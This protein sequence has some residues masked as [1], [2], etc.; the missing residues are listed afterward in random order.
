MKPHNHLAMIAV[1]FLALCPA[2]GPTQPQGIAELRGLVVDSESGEP[3]IGATI[4][5]EGFAFG[6][7]TEIDGRYSLE[8]PSGIYTVSV[9]R[10]GYATKTVTGVNAVTGLPTEL[11][12]SLKP[13]AIALETEIVVTAKAIESAEAGL[14]KIQQRSDKVTDGI[15]AELIS[16][17]SSSDASDALKRVTGVTMVGKHT[18]VRGLGGR[19]G[20][21][22]LNGA[23]LPSPEPHRAIVPMDLF[24]ASLL[25]HVQITKNFTPDRPGDFAGGSVEIVA[26]EFPENLTLT[27]SASSGFNSVAVEDDMLF[28]RGGDTDWLGVDDGVRALPNVI[29]DRAA[30][31]RIAERGVGTDS[32]GFTA[33]E[34]ELFGRA[35][36]NQWSPQTRTSQL[37]QGYNFSLG[38]E[39]HI[40]EE[41]R[42]GYVFSLNY[43]N[44]NKRQEEVR[45]T[46]SVGA[47]EELSIKA[48]YD[49]TSGANEVLWGTVLNGSLRLSAFHNIA[50]KTMYNR[51]AEDEARIFT[52]WNDDWKKEVLNYRLRYIERGLLST[53]LSGNHYLYSLL[54]SDIRWKFTYSKVNRQEPDNREVLYQREAAEEGEEERPWRLFADN[55]QSG[56]R[57]FYDLTEDEISGSFDWE[58]PFLAPAGVASKLKFGAFGRTKERDFLVR[59]FRFERRQPN[60]YNSDFIDLTLVPE[61]LFSD[62]YIS[63]DPSIWRFQLLETTNYEDSYNA[64]HDLVAGYLSLDMHITRL[65]RFIGGA[66]VEKSTQD[67]KLHNPLD[68]PYNPG[69]ADTSASL[70]DTD[71]LPSLSFVYR[72]DEKTNV[73]VAYGRTLARPDFRELAPYEYVNYQGGYSEKG[74]PNLKRSII[75]NLDLRGEIFPRPGELLAASVFYKRFIEPIEEVIQPTAQL[76]ISYDNAEKADS[77]GFELEIRKALDFISPKLR[78]FSANMNFTWMETEVTLPEKLGQVQ[79][80][81]I[82]PLQG[83]SPY[84]INVMLAYDNL[85]FGTSASLMFHQFGRRIRAAGGQG[86]PD[87]YEE[88]RPQVDITWKQ[89][90]V[91]HLTAKVAVKNLLDPNHEWTQGDETTISYRTGRSFSLG[92]TYSL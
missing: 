61:E 18:Y 41:Q 13:E 87:T 53:Q 81:S 78:E 35:F 90:V 50:M 76:R 5:F 84:V 85:A 2:I 39:L 27:A 21:T 57:H 80:S 49:V 6:T 52:G 10:I 91:P 33:E 92:M 38:N 83:Q 23:T 63:A 47:N 44:D 54:D 11:N 65:L 17:T 34:I 1:L 7:M 55:T 20:N 9:T 75:N 14:L 66:R 30:N 32:R 69:V 73:R 70:D 24:P 15:S 77:Y 62:E 37:N 89:K 51:S 25:D 60:P 29:E 74:N 82:R 36:K 19:Y 26:K 8:I 3:V 48:D 28:Y 4:M 45:R 42:L 58:L 46:Y 43:S 71:V 16:K 67:L 59:K 40:G 79:T 86:I 72:L 12:V 68:L 22:L 56:S 64:S 31:Q 88:T